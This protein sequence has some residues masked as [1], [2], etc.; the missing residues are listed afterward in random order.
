MSEYP[1][2]HVI[3]RWTRRRHDWIGYAFREG[4]RVSGTRQGSRLTTRRRTTTCWRAGYPEDV[5]EDVLSRRPTSNAIQ[6]GPG[7][8]LRHR[9]AAALPLAV[10]RRRNLVAVEVGAELG[11]LGTPEPGGQYP[12]ARVE[13]GG[14]RGFGH[15]HL[16]PFDAVVVASAFHWLDP[17]VPLLQIGSLLSG[18]AATSPSVHAHHVRGEARRGSSMSY[19]AVLPEVGPERRP[20]LPTHPALRDAP[21]MCPELDGRPEF[22]PGS[23]PPLRDSPPT[24]PLSPIVGWLKTDSLVATLDPERRRGRFPQRR[25]PTS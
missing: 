2:S 13:T 8:W 5:V 17:D 7:G 12:N 1:T 16:E 15:Y 23:A 3:L 25:R 6:S 4:S 14:L 21:I 10:P 20:V 11:G 9:P 18:R 22:G 19:P 24:R